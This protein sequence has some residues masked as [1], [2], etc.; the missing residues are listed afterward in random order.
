MDRKYNTNGEKAAQ[1]LASFHPDDFK[2]R[3]SD[4]KTL[5]RIVR[6]DKYCVEYIHEPYDP[7]GINRVYVTAGALR[8]EL[9]PSK[10]LSVGAVLHGDRMLLWQPLLE[11][12]PDPDC[13]DLAGSLIWNGK[14]VQGFG[15]I[16]YLVGGV[17]MFGLGNWG[18]PYEDRET[19]KSATLHGEVSNIP[20]ERVTVRA[21]K[22]TLD[23]S[24]EFFVHDGQGDASEVWYRR[25]K[26]LYRVRKRVLIQK[27]SS[28]VSVS[29]TILNVSGKKLEPDWGYSIKFQPYDGTEYLV[30]SSMVSLRSGGVVA[31]NHE[32]WRRAVI[33]SVREEKGIVHRGLQV[34]E[35][36][37]NGR[38]VETLV[39][40]RSGEGV[41][42]VVPQTPYF[43]SWYS[44]GG[45]GNREFMLP[46]DQGKGPMK[47]FEKSW[48]GI[49]PEFGISALDH[50]G[51]VDPGI[52]RTSL[53]PG[54]S[55]SV[56][57]FFQPIFGNE[58]R[59][60]EREIRAFNSTRERG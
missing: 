59:N 20:I 21:G 49:G 23:V 36:L 57:F 18:M 10:G 41:R 32:V 25:G 52:G 50:D 58:V 47:V 37:L 15:F 39:R 6:T 4:G 12:L 26:R 13:V 19:G 2:G 34:K 55:F 40:H 38:A 17:M 42:V 14:T 24:G 28:I 8:V 29:D 44:S 9:L 54:E 53:Q 30:P 46:D 1:T 45:K 43:L 51:D 27:G 22:Q 11:R 5:R 56:D 16:E 60:L 3:Y 7:P 48:N 35:T 31:Q 33:E